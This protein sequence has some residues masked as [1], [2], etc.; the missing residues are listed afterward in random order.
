MRDAEE[1]KLPVLKDFDKVHRTGMYK[2]REGVL[3]APVSPSK[4]VYARHSIDYSTNVQSVVIG[5]PDDRQAYARLLKFV[6]GEVVDASMW[7]ELL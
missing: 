6:D 4:T 1:A 7:Y 3:N 5:L 2:V